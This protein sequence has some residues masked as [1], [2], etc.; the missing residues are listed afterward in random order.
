MITTKPRDLPG[1]RLIGRTGD[2]HTTIGQQIFHL[3]RL[4]EGWCE[5]RGLE[6]LVH[7]YGI[8]A[9]KGYAAH[10]YLI[11]APL[12]TAENTDHSHLSTYNRSVLL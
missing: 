9:V 5:A 1:V 3:V 7:A 6:R 4:G 10:Q 8:D 11:L 2:L 12:L